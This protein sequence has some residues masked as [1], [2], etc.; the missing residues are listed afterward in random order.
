MDL[1]K[2]LGLAPRRKKETVSDLLEKKREM[3]MNGDF[4]LPKIRGQKHKVPN[5]PSHNIS[6]VEE[7]ADGEEFESSGKS[8]DYVNLTRDALKK[9]DGSITE[10]QRKTFNGNFDLGE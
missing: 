5:F 1:I 9:I 8:K 4:Q 6:I 3:A 10:R 2:E 7:E